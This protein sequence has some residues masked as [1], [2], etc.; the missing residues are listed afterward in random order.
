MEPLQTTLP[1]LGPFPST[2]LSGSNSTSGILSSEWA[3]IGKITHQIPNEFPAA[4][5]FGHMPMTLCP[6]RTTSLGDASGSFNSFSG[7]VTSTNSFLVQSTS[8]PFR[9]NNPFD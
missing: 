2:T 4:D 1:I 5:Y 8:Q 3:P 6:L 7:S 9:S